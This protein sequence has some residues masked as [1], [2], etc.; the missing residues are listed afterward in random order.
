ML[1][2]RMLPSTVNIAYEREKATFLRNASAHSSETNYDDEYDEDIRYG[3]IDQADEL[4][5]SQFASLPNNSSHFLL[6]DKR[7]IRGLTYEWS[8]R[9]TVS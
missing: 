1:I 8:D 9:T 4:I 6:Q 2:N 5:L 7:F 3:D